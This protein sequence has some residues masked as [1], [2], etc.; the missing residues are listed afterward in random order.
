MRSQKYQSWHGCTDEHYMYVLMLASVWKRKQTK[1]GGVIPRSSGLLK[2]C[3]IC[4]TG[5]NQLSQWPSPL[6]SS[7]GGNPAETKRGGS[8]NNAVDHRIVLS[9]DL[10]YLVLCY[11]ML[12]C[13]MCCL[14]LYRSWAV[15]RW[16][17]MEAWQEARG[18][19]FLGK[20]LEPHDSNLSGVRLSFLSC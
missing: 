20:D 12:L 16:G 6:L 11:N 10:I 4:H 3:G 15:V 5:V 19:S 9:V 14:R 2:P 18:S 17:A 13:C 7:A 8:S 1:S